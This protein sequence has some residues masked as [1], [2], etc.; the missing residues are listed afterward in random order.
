MA[1]MINNESNPVKTKWDNKLPYFNITL[2]G[3]RSFPIP[4]HARLEE[5]NKDISELTTIREQKAAEIAQIDRLLVQKRYE[6][7]RHVA[8][9]VG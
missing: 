1:R 3:Q 2:P 7:D 6:R 4:A 5:L 9:H 8:R